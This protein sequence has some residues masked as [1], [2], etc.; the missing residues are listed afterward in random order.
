[1]KP[2]MHRPFTTLP[3]RQRG[4][5][6]VLIVI[7]LASI[8]LMAALALDGGHMLLNKT[9]L[10]NAV[11]AAALSGAKTLSQVSGTP[12]GYL[13]AVAAARNTLASNAYADGNGELA[14]AVD[15]PGF[16]INV[17]FSDSVY[18]P[19]FNPPV[20]TDPRYVRVTVPDYP[21]V[22][23]LWGVLNMFGSGDLEKAVAAIATA[24]PSPSA[25]PCRIEPILVCGD[26]TKYDPANGNFWGYGFGELKVLKSASGTSSE[27][28]P[29]NFQLLRLDGA[30]G[31]DDL[32]E[33]LAGGIDRC[34]VVGEEA[35]TEPGNTVGPVAQGL[36]TRLGQYAGSMSADDYPPD[37][38]TD[39][40]SPRTTYNDTTSNVEYEGEVVSSSGG[41]LS[42]SSADLF[43][44]NDWQSASAA[45]AASGTCQGA[46]E[47]R[48]LTLVI[49][50][51]DGVS[52]GQTS[53]PVLGFGC[54]YLLQT[55][56]QQGTEAQV[57]GQ[58]IS[59]CEGDGY[60]GATPADDVGPSI[61]QLY[62]TYIGEGAG[63][64]SPDS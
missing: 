48:I 38:V 1:M 27:I 15:T 56:K 49:G 36:N 20:S 31:A 25:T 23:F 12:T 46:Y 33:A 51:C 17:E 60:A 45:C 14:D 26:P 64:P 7:A 9:R 37:W 57:F 22:G 3:A 50:N 29:G 2:R 53:V 5:V 24:G 44:Y 28:G 6:I 41:N 47:R 10:Q 43:D 40:T 19:F 16:V 52:G 55:V 8:L 21:L 4:A 54:F 61:I 35:E 13:A 59:E 39:F 18:G 62:K 32:R 63:E 58:F 42:T 34:N 11:D 30:A